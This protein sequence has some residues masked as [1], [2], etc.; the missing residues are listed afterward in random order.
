MK[1]IKPLL[2]AVRRA[3]FTDAGDGFTCMEC[4]REQESCYC[5]IPTW[6]EK[7]SK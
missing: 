3:G 4:G 2:K 5:G 7:G 1:N 6:D